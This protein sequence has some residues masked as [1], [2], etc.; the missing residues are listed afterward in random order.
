MPSF[1][2]SWT[3]IILSDIESQYL[4]FV[5]YNYIY[6]SV[7]ALIVLVK[8]SIMPLLC[9]VLQIYLMDTHVFYTIVSAI[10]GFL[11]GARDR[12]G[13]V[14][15]IHFCMYLCTL[16]NV[17]NGRFAFYYLVLDLQPPIF[18]FRWTSD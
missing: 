6:V 11:M 2:G 9:F 13:E 16:L 17:S 8:S 7:M 3:P 4:V 14:T 5:L 18:L 15:C 12:L 10:L 1:L